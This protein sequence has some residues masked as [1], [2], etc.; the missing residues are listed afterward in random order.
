MFLGAFFKITIESKMHSYFDSPPAIMESIVTFTTLFLC[1]F[2]MQESHESTH[3]SNTE[4]DAEG[5]PLAHLMSRYIFAKRTRQAILEVDQSELQS[6][7]DK[8]AYVAVLYQDDTKKCAKTLHDLE[9]IKADAFLFKISWRK[10]NSTDNCSIILYRNGQPV[11]FTGKTDRQ[12]AVLKWSIKEIYCYMDEPLDVNQHQFEVLIRSFRN[13]VLVL[14]SPK[15]KSSRQ[16]INDFRKQTDWCSNTNRLLVVSTQNMDVIKSLDLPRRPPLMLH[17]VHGLY[18]IYDGN[19]ADMNTIMEWINVEIPTNLKV[20]GESHLDRIFH[21]EEIV[22]VFFIDESTPLLNAALKTTGRDL[23]FTFGLAAVDVTD[24]QVAT[25]YNITSFPS[26][27]LYENGDFK[28][29]SRDLKVDKNVTQSAERVKQ[30]IIERLEA[31]DRI[32][33][34]E[35]TSQAFKSHPDEFKHVLL[36]EHKDSIQKLSM[37]YVRIQKENEELKRIIEAAKEALGQVEIVS[38]AQRNDENEGDTEKSKKKKRISD[39]CKNCLSSVGMAIWNCG[40]FEMDCIKGAV[41]LGS[42]CYPCI[43]EILD[44]WW[45]DDAPN[46]FKKEIQRITKPNLQDEEPQTNTDVKIE[47]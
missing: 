5:V 45:P 31:T 11:I 24:V 38:E 41:E 36:K 1:L 20:V 21:R 6:L 23:E 9:L 14:T 47:L 42:E 15:I 27:V 7:I 2:C 13:F 33:V 17:V 16:L 35:I 19:L 37:E 29:Y 46:C 12:T 34:K 8:E 10:M 44:Y 22:L 43:C 30:W 3:H 28:H 26:V 25:E 4:H 40:T 39:E 32:V 18:I